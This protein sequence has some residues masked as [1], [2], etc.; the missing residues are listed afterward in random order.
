MLEAWNDFL[1]NVY[2]DHKNLHQNWFHQPNPG[3]LWVKYSF[4][5]FH[6]YNFS[7]TLETSPTSSCCFQLHSSKD[8]KFSATAISLK[9]HVF[10]FKLCCSVWCFQV[11]IFLIAVDKLQDCKIFY[12]S[13]FY[14]CEPDRRRQHGQKLHF[15][16]IWS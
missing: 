7:V 1:V 6:I 16:I 12:N 2:E 8:I 9:N 13:I 10:N 3:C 11:F 15:E 14:N 4:D 5:D